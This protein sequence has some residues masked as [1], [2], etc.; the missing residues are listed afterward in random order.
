MQN[1][2]NHAPLFL[3]LRNAIVDGFSGDAKKF[4]EREFDFFKK[5][6]SVSGK[7]KDYPKGQARKAA[8][9]KALQEIE[10]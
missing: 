4:Y 9:V 6:T 8:C 10:V 1:L 3:S 5:V 7:I 2:G